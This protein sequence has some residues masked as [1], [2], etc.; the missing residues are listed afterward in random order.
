EVKVQHANKEIEVLQLPDSLG[1]YLY[2]S[3]ALR[4]FEPRVDAVLDSVVPGAP[5]DVAGLQKGDRL[6]SVNGAAITFWD[7]FTN[8]VK[9]NQGNPIDLVVERNKA[10]E[11]ISI[12][13]VD[14]KVGVFVK[15]PDYSNAI[16]KRTYS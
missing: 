16:H 5:A 11:I 15:L 1:T 9:E 4:P 12:T 2:V 7:E 14:Q 3:G 6:V 13:P 10:T 8:V